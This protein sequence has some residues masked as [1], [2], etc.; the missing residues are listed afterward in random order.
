MGNVSDDELDSGAD[1]YIE[2]SSGSCPV[3]SNAGNNYAQQCPTNPVDTPTVIGFTGEGL[4]PQI[5]ERYNKSRRLSLSHSIPGWEQP[6]GVEPNQFNG[7]NRTQ[8]APPFPST[9]SEDFSQPHSIEVPEI[10]ITEPPSMNINSSTHAQHTDY[11][12]FGYC[13]QGPPGTDEREHPYPGASME[14]GTGSCDSFTAE[15][16]PHAPRVGVLGERPSDDPHAA[17]VYSGGWGGFGPFVIRL[18][19]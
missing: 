9:S 8:S 13:Y 10:I 14:G 6:V 19:T 2:T 5:L 4:S 3:P 18:R 7:F 1:V 17:T 16:R 11:Q 12:D 15:I